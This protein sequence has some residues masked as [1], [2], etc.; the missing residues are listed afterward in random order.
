VGRRRDATVKKEKNECTGTH[1]G[2]GWS[3]IGGKAGVN[4]VG[5]TGG[6]GTGKRKQ[7]SG[8]RET[9]I[10]QGKKNQRIGKEKK[11]Q[12]GQRGWGE[13]LSKGK[14]ERLPL[15]GKGEKKRPKEL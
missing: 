7:D 5:R 9:T 14:L 2:N 10:R 3:D 1:K 11:G 13:V 8:L 4:L 12:A 15:R 6:R